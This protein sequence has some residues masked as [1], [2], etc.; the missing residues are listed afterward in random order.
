[1]TSR[2]PLININE[3]GIEQ[4]VALITSWGST[5]LELAIFKLIAAMETLAKYG[6]PGI[7]TNASHQ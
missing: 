7:Q 2:S 5:L 4:A 1:M 3:G 6:P